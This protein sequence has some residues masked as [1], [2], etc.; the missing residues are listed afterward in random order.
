[1]AG[2]VLDD[3][4]FLAMDGSGLRVGAALFLQLAPSAIGL[5]RPILT[6]FPARCIPGRVRI[7]APGVPHL[8]TARTNIAVVLI[9]PFEVGSGE[10]AIRPLSLVEDRDERKDLAL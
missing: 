3:F 5:Q 2:E 6:R 4:V 7:G 10:R 9:I 8:F 1:L